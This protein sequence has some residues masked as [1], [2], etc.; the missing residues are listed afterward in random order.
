MKV[1]NRSG[2]WIALGIFVVAALIPLHRCLL[3][4][5]I[6]PWADVLAMVPGHALNG[7]KPW[8][9]LQA[10][11][12]LQFA[13][14]RK[15]VFQAYATG[16]IPFWNFYSLAGTPL[17]ANSQSGALYPPHILVGIARIPWQVGI[18][19][20]AW[21]HVIWAMLGTYQL[22]GA[23][24]AKFYPRIFAGL[25]F[26]LSAFLLGWLPLS[27]VVETCSW[28]P[29][30][31]YFTV[32]LLDQ[33]PHPKLVW[34]GPFA[35]LA[36]SVAMLFLAG[37]LQF[38]AYGMIAI[39]LYGVC[40]LVSNRNWSLVLPLVGALLLGFVVASPQVIPV[41]QLGKAS[42]RMNS[43][44]PG[45]YSGY[46]SSALPISTA[47]D[48]VDP[49]LQGN[50]RTLAA[51]SAK[52]PA[53]SSL[54]AFWPA[55]TQRGG[56]FAE[57][58]ISPGAAV[59]GALIIFFRRKSVKV[60]TPLLV[61]AA[62]SVLVAFGTPLNLALFYGIPGWSATGSPGR[63]GV[64]FVLAASVLASVLVSAEPE[65]ESQP[66]QKGGIKPA[67]LVLGAV[68]IV[69][70]AL[71]V[72]FLPAPW[73]PGIGQQLIATLV[74]SALIGA[75]PKLLITAALLYAVW[76]A[77]APTAAF[78]AL[79]LVPLIPSITQTSASLVP[80][81]NASIDAQSTDT[82]RS[83]FLN[84]NWGLLERPNAFYPP[85]TA[86]LFGYHDVAGYDSLLLEKT[87]QNIRVVDGRDPAPPANGNMMLVHPGANLEAL[88]ELG[89]TAVNGSSA[90]ETT[91]VPT[92]GLGRYFTANGTVPGRP[93]AIK[94]ESSDGIVVQPEANGTL[95]I[96]DST[97]SSWSASQNGIPLTIEPLTLNDGIV[98]SK[99]ENVQAGSVV[100]FKIVPR[101][102]VLLVWLS[103]L[104]SL[105]LAVIWISGLNYKRNPSSG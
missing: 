6:G 24:R 3:G 82:S 81:G 103:V 91:A 10:D 79:G 7:T 35:G 61:V 73:D 86:A 89:V 101:F 42:H 57:Y 47:L 36:C 13:L 58:A 80:T 48:I 28:I 96:T 69:L 100:V 90:A 52:V 2:F 22:A 76:K 72:R 66:Q 85:N 40:Y 27:S 4:E 44:G 104:T 12:V 45:D 15:L 9:V 94:E 39:V 67:W 99:I 63:I 92:Q 87:Y 19:L 26:G 49:Y 23:H 17:L 95:T 25:S 65:P 14:W 105:S 88:S 5:T 84:R 38:V 78:V 34:K 20:L 29:W 11:S 33:S 32:R 18:N 83:A 60:A 30:C 37:H 46:V 41:L 93:A 56:N 55:L 68:G 102:F 16:H 31:L 70:P 8:D 97:D 71:V 64:L 54:T 62:F 59:I 21:G 74:S 53:N 98:I 50:P 51:D 77:K 43:A 75:L 1:E